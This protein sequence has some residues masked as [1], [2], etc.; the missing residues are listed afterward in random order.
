M[1]AY[2]RM[3]FILSLA[4]AFNAAASD[5]SKEKRWADQVVDSI[6]DGDE[7]WLKQDSNKFLGIYTEAATN[8][9]RGLVIMHGMGV[10]PNWQQVVQPLRVNLAEHN[11]NT[12]S[13]QMPILRNEAEH[14]EYA[15][16]FDEVAPRINAAINHLRKNGSKEI[17]LVAHSLGS[18][19]AAHYL[20]KSQKGIKGFVA[21]GMSGL[22]K[23]SR[24]NSIRSLEKINIPM[25]DL[26]GNEDLDS[27][28]TA[29]KLRAD[30]A[31]KAGNKH[32]VQIKITGNHF[33]D[34]QEDTLVKTVAKWLEK[35]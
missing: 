34:G 11:W 13:I 32:Y 7:V 5:L 18:S 14:N 24:M 4:L 26:Y 3:V 31:N 20:S 12:L 16:L 28:M 25:L 1:T 35:I 6:I 17:V 21:I 15:P 23:D 2:I 19:M 29:T 33:F 30:A 8:K 10:H 9:N 22:A 27:V